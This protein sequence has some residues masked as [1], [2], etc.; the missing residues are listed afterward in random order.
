MP[1][2]HVIVFE[3]QRLCSFFPNPNQR[4]EHLA[5]QLTK[6]ASMTNQF[7]NIL[8]TLSELISKHTAR[9]LHPFSQTLIVQQI[10]SQGEIESPSRVTRWSRCVFLCA[11]KYNSYLFEQL[12]YQSYCMELCCSTLNYSKPF[13][14]LFSPVCFL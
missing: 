11:Y 13:T 9:L 8:L 14:S 5:M 10:H 4:L 1:S 12:N 7:L 2:F 6:K 3:F